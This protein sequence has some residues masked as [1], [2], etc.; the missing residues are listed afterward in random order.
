[1]STVVPDVFSVQPNESVH[2]YHPCLKELTS[3]NGF[4]LNHAYLVVS[5]DMAQ[6]KLCGPFTLGEAQNHGPQI[7]DV[8][9]TVLIRSSPSPGF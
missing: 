4:E 6:P 2:P 1:M 9:L 3:N 5:G 7:L 8:I